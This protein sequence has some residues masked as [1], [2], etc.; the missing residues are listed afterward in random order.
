[1]SLEPLTLDEVLI[2]C[3]TAIET[4][5]NSNA[6][7]EWKEKLENLEYD[8]AINHKLGH[9]FGRAMRPGIKRKAYGFLKHYL[10]EFNYQLLSA[11]TP[12]ERFQT[13]SHELAH[14][15]DYDIRKK[16]CHD[17]Q[18][19]RLHSDMGGDG[20]RCGKI[21]TVPTGR[22][23]YKITDRTTN[24]IW[25]MGTRRFNRYIHVF[26]MNKDRYHWEELQRA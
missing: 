13:V 3:H 4:F 26:A 7:P 14:I 18:W 21:A 1:M 9:I 25:Y 11:C 19:K 5:L 6:S 22:D 24:K 16:F 8:V 17:H 23:K 10:L 20:K 12:D 15:L 2:H